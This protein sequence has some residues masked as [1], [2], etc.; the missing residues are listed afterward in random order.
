MDPSTL[1]PTPDTIP[2]P[3]WLFWLL[4]VVTFTL[5]ILVINVVLGG[6]LITLFSRLRQPAADPQNLLFGPL[7]KKL[8]TGFAIAIN[9]G[10][11]PLLFVQVIYGHLI[12]SS[13]VL[14]AVYWILVIPLLIIAYY[15]AYIHAQKSAARTASLISIAVTSVI[16]LYI[17]F[18]YVNNMTLMVMPEKWGAYFENRGGTILN[19]GDPSF[20]P[21]YLHMVVASVAI[22]GLFLAIIWNYRSKRGEEGSDK[23]K[24]GLKIF[25]WATVAQIVIGLWFLMS[26]PKEIMMGFMGGNLLYTIVLTLGILLAIGVL[27]V[28]FRG[29]LTATLYHALAIVV[30]MVISRANLRSLYLS[31]DFHLDTLQLSPQYGVMALFFVIFG[32][33]LAVV[34]YMLKI[35]WKAN[36]V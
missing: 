17:A 5:H 24:S 18:T 23:V 30:L 8:P 36:K 7:V 13:S 32:I 20:W 4:N 22:A 1:I 15:S 28:A 12:Y 31:D 19:A 34:Y 29:K 26:L 3:W 33:G 27:F 16:L 35:A 9:L 11:A 6:S 14:M 25:A 10:V 2:A 21:R